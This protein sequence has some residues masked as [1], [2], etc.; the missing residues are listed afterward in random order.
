MHVQCQT[1]WLPKAGNSAAEYE[2]A[3]CPKRANSYPLKNMFRCAVADGATESSFAR[4]WANQLAV[5]YC[6]SQTDLPAE[7]QVFRA[8]VE[9]QC[10]NWRRFVLNK[11]L[12]W[13]FRTKAERG[14]FAT[15]SGIT[16]SA[17]DESSGSWAGVAIGDS[18]IFQVRQEGLVHAWPAMESDAFGNHPLLFSSNAAANESV[19]TELEKCTTSGVWSAG[20]LFLLMTDA[21]AKWFV[22]SLEAGS[23]PWETLLEVASAQEEF[24]A[25]T[26]AQRS[27][28]LMA[29]DDVTLMVIRLENV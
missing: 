16:I 14:A 28:H 10:A 22:T 24:T 5:A 8:E 17:G 23:R 21:L 11:P 12:A 1:C 26:E 13:N 19:W 7:M 20:D 6:R 25:W 2:D 15:L 18:C 29:N 9:R 27:Q 4:R 3:F